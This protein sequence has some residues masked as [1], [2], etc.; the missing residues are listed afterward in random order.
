MVTIY[1]VKCLGILSLKVLPTTCFCY[2]LDQK[3]IKST[4]PR[5]KLNRINTSFPA[6]IK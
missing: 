6:E 3:C 4:I 2:N 1:R 5:M